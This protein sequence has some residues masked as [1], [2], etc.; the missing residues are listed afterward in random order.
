MKNIIFFRS[1]GELTARNVTGH[2][3]AGKRR[4]SWF[5]KHAHTRTAC[6][7]MYLHY[8][9]ACNHGNWLGIIAWEKVYG[10]T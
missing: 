9:F 4:D 10:V 7:V 6:G 2:C 1:L 3:H 8:A 5:L